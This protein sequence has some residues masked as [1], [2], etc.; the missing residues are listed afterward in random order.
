MRGRSPTGSPASASTS[1]RPRVGVVVAVRDGEAHL[2]AALES[3]L[4]QTYES[5]QCV[6]VDDGSVDATAQVARSFTGDG[7]ISVVRHTGA[8]AG[9]ARNRGLRELEDAVE[10]LAFLDGDDVWL[11]DALQRLVDAL[12][13]A[14]GAVGAYGTAEYV[15][16]SGA[17]VRVGEHPARQRDRRRVRGLDL[18]PV[19][20]GDPWTTFAA[21]V[22]S[23]P[24]WPAAVVLLRRAVVE[25]VDGFDQDLLQCQDWDLYLRCSRYG[26]LRFLDEQVAWY[27]QHTTNVTRD[28][29][30][31]EHFQDAVRRRARI[32]GDNTRAQRWVAERA[33]RAVQHRHVYRSARRLLAAAGDRDGER[34]RASAQELRLRCGELVRPSRSSP[35]PPAAGPR[36]G[37]GRA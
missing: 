5:W 16:A 30:R 33:W 2:A 11:D 28:V 26:H 18:G 29:A 13:G 19:P 8:G 35:P 20:A 17:P 12:D 7:R 22:V 37:D 23:G 21:L 31:S 27:R 25:A 14:P 32:S 10:L 4:A 9:A 6:V 34:V 24:V 3:V 36:H 1:P 15:D